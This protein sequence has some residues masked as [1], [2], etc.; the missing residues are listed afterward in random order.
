MTRIIL[1]FTTL[2]CGASVVSR[3]TSRH[4]SRNLATSRTNASVQFEVARLS[5]KITEP[6]GP[7]ATEYSDAKIEL[8]VVTADKQGNVWAG[9]AY[10][11]AEG[12]LL[13]ASVERVSVI[14]LPSV[15]NEVS[16]L[17]FTS[18]RTGWMIGD[19]WYLYRTTDG[20]INWEKIWMDERLRKAK[21]PTRL[22][23][24]FFADEEHGW[25][26]GASGLIYNTTDGGTKWR[27]QYSG[28]KINLKKIQFVDASHGWA[29]GNDSGLA[30]ETILIAT[31]N[32]GLNW[33]TL[34]RGST[35]SLKDF[36]FVTASKGW[37]INQHGDV[38]H[39]NNGGDT[40]LT[41]RQNDGEYFSI[42]LFFNELD[43]LIIGD[44]ILHTSNGGLTWE[45]Q[46]KLGFF[47][48]P[49]RAAFTDKLH[50]WAIYPNGI[51]VSE[52]KR[53]T[54]GG[55]SWE[56]ISDSWQKLVDRTA[57]KK[58]FGEKQ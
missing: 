24:I 47:V 40:W 27:K 21:N 57:Y 11:M 22:N 10:T 52:L 6:S 41:Q 55:R 13:Q 39:T 2:V 46:Q 53:T 17:L 19:W 32:G 23:S 43:G 14:M 26:A 33:K 49:R 3:A 28:T 37:G 38:V 25:V 42:V 48:E 56:S 12:F 7:T 35:L 45:S 18:P 8:N 15:R 4:E 1:I 44:S 16:D 34:S 51:G 36:T 58:A 20:G 50:G 31:K 54:N 30:G 5:L 29:I 9:G